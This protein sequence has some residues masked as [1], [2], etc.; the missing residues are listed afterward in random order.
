[1][2]PTDNRTNLAR[3]GRN[4]VRGRSVSR[5]EALAGDDEG[6]RVGAKVEEELRQDVHGQQAVL[7]QLVVAEAHDDEEDGEDGETHQLNRLA[8]D[9]V[10]RR[11]GHPVAW[12]RTSQDDDEVADGGVVEVL[13]GGLGAS[14]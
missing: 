11:H 10:H 5:G 4:T 9:G 3:S 8:A 13:V 12:D 14:G 2:G 7:T 6:S 1:M